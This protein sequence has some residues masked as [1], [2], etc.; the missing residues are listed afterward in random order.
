MYESAR[1][2]QPS[3]PADERSRTSSPGSGLETVAALAEEATELELQ[4]EWEEALELFR[5]VIVEFGKA[6]E[7]EIRER[8]AYSLLRTGLILC[9]KHRRAE[10]QAALGALLKHFHAGESAAIDEH[11]AAGLE[12]YQLL[13]H[14]GR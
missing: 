11:L 4:D 6:D 7:V 12:R 13:V 9:F 5:R 2:L 14:R 3:S 1:R 10:A 8:V